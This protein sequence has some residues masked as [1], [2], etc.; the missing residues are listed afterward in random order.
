MG[1][2]DKIKK[3]VTDAK[4]QFVPQ[5]Q[6][7]AAAPPPEP[8]DE[9]ADDD[10]DESEE[11][12]DVAGFDVNRDEQSFFHAVLHMESEGMFGGTDESRAEICARFGIRDRSHWQTVKESNYALLARKYGSY[13]EVSQQEL[14][15]RQGQMQQHMVGQQQAMAAK[16]GFEPVE[17]VSLEAW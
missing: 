7:S 3:S 6:Q 12:F 16:G 1:L 2:F 5:Q 11:Q 8:E 15:W 10:T 14:N 13:E 17:G 4:N 9:P